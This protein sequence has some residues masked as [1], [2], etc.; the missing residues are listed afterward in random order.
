M[1]GDLSKAVEQLAAVVLHFQEEN[2]N[3]LE[4][5]DS[6]FF[7]IYKKEYSKLLNRFKIH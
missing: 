5:I 1:A 6:T 2:K 7:K 4:S 3:S